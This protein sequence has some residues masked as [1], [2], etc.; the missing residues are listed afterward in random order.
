[1]SEGGRRSAE[2]RVF[3]GLIGFPGGAK[4]FSVERSGLILLAA[5]LTFSL[6]ADG[7]NVRSKAVAVPSAEEAYRHALEVVL[8]GNKT[9]I[10]DKRVG[11]I[12]ALLT[13]PDDETRRLVQQA[14]AEI[15]DA[16]GYGKIALAESDRVRLE[17][18]ALTIFVGSKSDGRKLVEDFGVSS[19]RAFGGGVYYY[20]WDDG[21][22]NHIRRCLIAIDE[23]SLR[24]GST[25]D[26][27]HLI[28]A[29]MG[30]QSP[31]SASHARASS[32]ADAAG[33]QIFSELDVAIIRFFDKHVPPGAKAWE[34][35]NIFK[36]EWPDFSSAYWNP[37]AHAGSP[38]QTGSRGLP[39]AE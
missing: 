16:Y 27:R 30:L 5:L 38:P 18:D 31:W 11:P 10:V 24:H 33:Q 37:S 21:R 23:A 15:N 20:W 19:P 26:L 2:R 4:I 25:Q 35:R 9:A 32:P 34:M 1:L 14:V 39:P 22:N 3:F 12:R 6:S 8:G 13:A 7:S 28:A 17:D 29:S 36:R